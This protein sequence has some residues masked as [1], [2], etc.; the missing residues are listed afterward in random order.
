MA[1]NFYVSHCVNLISLQALEGQAV[2]PLFD[3]D[4]EHVTE[5]LSSTQIGCQA[6]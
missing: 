1:V 6:L 3:A 2:G 5:K 4:Y